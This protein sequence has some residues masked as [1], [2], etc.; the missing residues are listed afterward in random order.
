[1]FEQYILTFLALWLIIMTI[2]VQ[3]FTAIFVNRKYGK[4]VPGKFDND[5]GPE[6]F[7]F[8]SD[9][10]FK[11]SLENIVQFIVPVILAI[12]LDVNNMAL[13]AIVWIYAI[14]RIGHMI[15][16]YRSTSS[17]NPS[18]KSYF[19]LLGVLM[20]VILMVMVL[21]QIFTM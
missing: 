1:M 2:I 12:H 17:K 7:I 13:A 11:N 5:L 10:T 8:R 20:N 15:A 18:A 14:A 19:F 21:V 3:Q 6:S 16:Y 4:F 9:R